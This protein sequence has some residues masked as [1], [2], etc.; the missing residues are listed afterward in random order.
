MQWEK[1]VTTVMIRQ[2][3]RQC[4][5]LMLL[6]EIKRRGFGEVF[7]FLYLPWDFKKCVNVGYGFV[8][9]METSQAKAFRD[10]F[11]GSFMD[12]ST[13]LKSCGKPLRVHPAA[14]QGY[15]ANFRHFAHTKTGQKMNPQYSP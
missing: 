9:F 8:N 1:G 3:P 13:G 2:V 10:K 5:Q 7:D 12:K 11:D 4:S 6:D 15:A 14:V